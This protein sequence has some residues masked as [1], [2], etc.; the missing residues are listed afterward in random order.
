MTERRDQRDRPSSATT[1]GPFQAVPPDVHRKLEKV[2][3]PF[4]AAAGGPGGWH[5]SGAATRGL[6]LRLELAGGGSK[7]TVTVTPASADGSHYLRVGRFH[8]GYL[9]PAE[10]EPSKRTLALADGVGRALEEPGVAALVSALFAGSHPGV[11]RTDFQFEPDGRLSDFSVEDCDHGPDEAPRRLGPGRVLSREGDGLKVYRTTADKGRGSPLVRAKGVLGRVRG[12]QGQMMEPAEPCRECPSRFDCAVCFQPGT[13]GTDSG[14]GPLRENLEGASEIV[15][16]LGSEEF[17]AFVKSLARGFGRGVPLVVVEAAP[18]AD[19]EFRARLADQL[20]EAGPG[21][22][23]LVVGRDP[24]ARM[25]PVD[26]SREPPVAPAEAPV[27]AAGLSDTVMGLVDYGLSGRD[28][29]DP[30]FLRYGL[31]PNV[32]AMPVIRHATVVVNRKCVTICRYCDL[33]LR[34]RRNMTLEEAFHVIEEAGVLG[35]DRMEFFGGEVTLRKDL[36]D[37][38]AYSRRL[39]MQTFVTT[40]G[41]GLDDDYL[42]ELA[43]SR[44]TDISVSIDSAVPAV[45]DY[46]KNREGMHEAAVRAA[47]TLKRF[48]A[49]W[50]GLNSVIVG[51]NYRQLPGVVELAADLG[52]QGAIFFFCQPVAE[53]G[54][55]SEILSLDQARELLDEVLPACRRLAAERGVSLGVRPALDTVSTGGDDRARR[56]SEATYCS[57]FHT[58]DPCRVAGELVSVDPVGDVRLCNQPLMQFGSDSVVGNVKEASLAHILSSPAA[59]AFR[60]GAGRFGECRHC[61]FDHEV[62]PD[63]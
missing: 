48:G 17:Q 34:I 55:R 16:V 5:L 14:M 41:V 44:V 42:R 50:V 59:A 58:D 20:N 51:E 24:V 47:V 11:S 38:L 32:R 54:K 2:L 63:E 39:G 46:L 49:P 7:V 22:Q 35:V 4:A 53:M 1:S 61:T 29:A 31:G 8:V 9:G 19:R 3:D 52:L 60:E 25:G 43:A 45:H 15:A 40:T 6:E 13:G 12:P 26:D 28:G 56:V 10:G 21:T 36:F 18:M 37:L 57:I 27:T 62:P 30:W 33:P 23:V